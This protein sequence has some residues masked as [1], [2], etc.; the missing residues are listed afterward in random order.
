MIEKGLRF[1][2]PNRPSRELSLLLGF[3]QNPTMSQHDIAR[4]AGISSSM[5]HNYVKAFV[6]QGLI[7]IHG[8]TNRTM[9]YVVTP[10]GQA[11]TQEL[12]A[13]YAEEVVH[14]YTL[15]KHECARKLQNLHRQG[16]CNVVLFG[17]AATG[18]LVYNAAQQ[19]PLRI[20]GVVDNDPAKHHHRFGELE[21]LPP[22][23]ISRLRPD[24]VI[25]TAFGRPDEIYEQI[26][27]LQDDGIQVVRL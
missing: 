24:G 25:I 12:L 19:T 7:Q 20:L 14:L 17:A 4:L 23:V 11:R 10:A 5:A 2:K 18:E 21:V 8:T 1:F 13:Q 3:E 6:D 9:R 22:S 27:H 15:A 26:R 16:L